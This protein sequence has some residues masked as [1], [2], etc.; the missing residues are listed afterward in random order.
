[1]RLARDTH[2]QMR[3]RATTSCITHAIIIGEA[4]C[5]TTRLD[6]STTQVDKETLVFLLLETNVRSATVPSLSSKYTSGHRYPHCSY[7][8]FWDKPY[9]F[10]DLILYFNVHVVPKTD[11]R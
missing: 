10:S 5:T 7:S 1:M 11:Y 3:P 8:L 4:T 6:L 9:A 2:A